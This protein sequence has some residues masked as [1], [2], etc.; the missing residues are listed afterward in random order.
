LILVATSLTLKSL[1]LKRFKIITTAEFIFLLSTLIKILW[2]GYV[3]T[4][5]SIDDLQ[6]FYP[7]SLLN[8]IG[9][10]NLQPWAIYPFQILNLFELAYWIFIIYYLNKS[11]KNYR[12]T[13]ILVTYSYGLTLIVW[14]ISVLF[15][16]LTLY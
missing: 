5:F 10:W 16:V 15:V 14:V 12:K 4:N 7:L 9:Y 6:Y 2:F 3:H 11:I 8:I 1:F 13:I